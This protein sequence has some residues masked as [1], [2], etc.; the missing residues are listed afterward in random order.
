[1]SFHLLQTIGIHLGLDKD[2]DGDVDL[3]DFYL[4]FIETRLGS[5]IVEKLGIQSLL[6]R[7]RKNTSLTATNET[8]METNM[9][10]A[11]RLR[12]EAKLLHQR[13]DQIAVL[14]ETTTT[15]RREESG[16]LLFV[17]V[18]DYYCEREEKKRR[19]LS[20]ILLL[21][22]FRFFLLFFTLHFCWNFSWKLA[23]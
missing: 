12:E 19:L 8:N 15:T 5:W 7:R 10:A 18:V 22:W 3:I 14:L 20:Y 1:M 13:M 11:T 23:S 2:G 21:F 9:A 4:I 17:V 16:A 6:S